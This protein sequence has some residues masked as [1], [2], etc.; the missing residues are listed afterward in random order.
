MIEFPGLAQCAA[1]G[2]VQ[3]LWQPLHDVASLINLASGSPR[4]ARSSARSP[5][6]EPSPRR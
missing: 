5:W 3:R 1:D 2:S 4:C 6:R